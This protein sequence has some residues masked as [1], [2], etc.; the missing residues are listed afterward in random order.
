MSASA[1]DGAEVLRQWLERHRHL[2]EGEGGP[3]WQHC[4]RLYS[5][6]ARGVEAMAGA[7]AARSAGPDAR[8]F[9]PAGW[10]RPAGGG[11]M[12]DLFR[13]LEGPELAAPIAGL[14]A[15]ALRA[16]REWIAYL[17]ATEQMKAVLA[18]GWIAAFRAFLDRAAG[19]DRAG[20]P[21]GWDRMLAIWH[22][23]AAAE[24]ARTH[25]SAAFLAA[26]RDLVA[27]ETALRAHL[28]GHVERLAG[29]LGLPT[30]AELD[31][32]HE[33]LHG[34]GRE[35]RRMR[36]RAREPSGTGGA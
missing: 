35:M 25:R 32:V 21:P 17:T 13:W 2:L 30:R 8:P 9:D 22:E 18:E 11:G 12:A 26:Q 19:E 24:F 10:L 29:E 16:T 28:R 31:D 1:R 6:W 5:A 27:A 34:L 23:T 14:Q 7:H 33:T 20:A 4:E 3:L 15:E 36:A